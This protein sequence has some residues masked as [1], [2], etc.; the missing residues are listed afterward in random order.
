MDTVFKL[1]SGKPVFFSTTA[2]KII[3]LSVSQSYHYFVSERVVWAAQFNASPLQETLLFLHAT[4]SQVG[5]GL[6]LVNI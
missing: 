2:V 1:L 3:L 6:I 5:N 4:L